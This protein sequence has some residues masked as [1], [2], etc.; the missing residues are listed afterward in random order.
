VASCSRFFKTFKNACIQILKTKE[1]KILQKKDE[2]YEM[3]FINFSLSTLA[4]SN[5]THTMST[6]TSHTDLAATQLHC[7]TSQNALVLIDC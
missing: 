7:A 3:E 1:R 5:F 4:A 2:S 6:L